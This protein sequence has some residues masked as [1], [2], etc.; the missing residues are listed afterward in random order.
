MDY[1]CILLF[2]TK[3]IM[4][5]LNRCMC[6]FYHLSGWKYHFPDTS[7]SEKIL[8]QSVMWR[9]FVNFKWF[10]KPQTKV[11]SSSGINILYLSSCLVL[12]ILFFSVKNKT[13][14]MVVHHTYD[15]SNGM[16]IPHWTQYN[17]DHVGV[18]FY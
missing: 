9:Q 8:E 11:S 4:L 3:I 10:G 6:L 5:A 2:S 12:T 16:K 1:Y 13:L 17:Y 7:L 14:I 18:W 15:F